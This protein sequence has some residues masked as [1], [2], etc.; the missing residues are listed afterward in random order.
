MSLSEQEAYVDS[1]S[2]EV[3]NSLI[4]YTE[5]N[6]KDFNRSLRSGKILTGEFLDHLHNIDFA[7]N[8][9]PPF[10]KSIVVYRGVTHT[11]QIVSDKSFM[12]TTTS[13]NVAAGFSECCIMKITISAGSK[14]LPLYYISS[15]EDELEILLNRDQLLVITH[16][17]TDK[18][19]KE[20]FHVN[21]LPYTSTI[22]DTEKVVEI[23]KKIDTSAY[24]K[25]A[26]SIVELLS[27][28]DELEMLNIEEGDEDLKKQIAIY[29][30]KYVSN[31]KNV[32]LPTSIPESLLSSITS[33]I[34]KSV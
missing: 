21:Y 15:Q 13:Y 12:S 10:E 8:G 27:D 14:I 6:Y 7:F 31:L 33:R 1:L 22:V 32:V 5:H 23:E 17:N 16:K 28:P 19:N 34:I 2:E 3:K 29:Y 4:W 11:S 18:N 30:R 24:E 20:I 25:I 26:D 9:V